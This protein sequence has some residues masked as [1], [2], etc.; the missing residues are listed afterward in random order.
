MRSFQYVRY[1]P[2]LM[3]TDGLQKWS[4]FCWKL[5]LLFETNGELG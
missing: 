2:Q 4:C 3:R 1:L 5:L